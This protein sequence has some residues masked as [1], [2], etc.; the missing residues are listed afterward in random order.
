MPSIER[1]FARLRYF[2]SFTLPFS[3][4]LMSDRARWEL[5]VPSGAPDEGRRCI[6]MM[7]PGKVCCPALINEVPPHAPVEFFTP[8]PSDPGMVGTS[9]LPLPMAACILSIDGRTQI[10]A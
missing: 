2:H 1:S 8:R 3:Y 7:I 6:D 10:S 5:D 4:E 9:E